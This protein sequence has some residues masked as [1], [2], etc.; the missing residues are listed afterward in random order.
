MNDED[1]R[2]SGRPARGGPGD[3]GPDFSGGPTQRKPIVSTP[4]EQSILRGREIGLVMLDES[5][6]PSSAR[7][8]AFGISPELH[9]DLRSDELV[10]MAQVITAEDGGSLR[11]F[12]GGLQH[13][14]GWFPSY[15]AHRLQHWEGISARNF[16]VESECNPRVGRMQSEGVR[17]RFYLPPKWHTYTADMDM[18]VDGVRHVVE[19]KPRADAIGD[20]EYRLVLSA[21]AEICRRCG[22]VFRLVLGTE[23]FAN[24]HHRDNCE[25]FAARRFVRVS[26]RVIDKLEGFA[27]KRGAETTYGELAEVLAPGCTPLGEA[28][29]QALSVRQRIEIDLTTR[30]Y[31]RT[32][33]RIL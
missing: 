17:F 15:K 5:E 10:T 24:R 2:G 6:A 23:V 30:V 8:R 20:E 12:S 27:M 3:L 19:V 11:T 18:T 9:P 1:E 21:V 25:L 28:L 14:C 32:P 4:L 31:H 16:I 7:L 33:L 22:W 29:I 13:E 26:E